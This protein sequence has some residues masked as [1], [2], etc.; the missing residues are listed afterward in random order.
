[1]RKDGR[2]EAGRRHFDWFLFVVV[3][4]VGYFS[5][6]VFFQQLTLNAVDRDYEAAQVRLKTAKEE[7]EALQKEKTDLNDPVYIEKI[8]REE[9]GMTKQGELPYISSKK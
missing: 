7:N 6:T 5:Y 2:K 1:M 9:L 8:A 4:I 3:C